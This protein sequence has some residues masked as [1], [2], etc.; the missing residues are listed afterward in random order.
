[1]IESFKSTKENKS[2]DL[3]DFKDPFDKSKCT[4]IDIF[5]RNDSFWTKG[6]T[7]YTSRITFKNGNTQGTHD[8]NGE[9]FPD[10][11]KKIESFISSL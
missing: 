4:D 1:M 9:N 6:I 10:L 5:I 7:E 11:L 8:I 3:T 2:T